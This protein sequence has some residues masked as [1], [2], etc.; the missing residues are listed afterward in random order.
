MVVVRGGT[1]VRQLLLTAATSKSRNSPGPRSSKPHTCTAALRVRAYLTWLPM[2]QHAA[3]I[4]STR[5]PPP[6]PSWA[7]AAR[8]GPLCPAW[9]L[10][11][12]QLP[13]PRH[14]RPPASPTAAISRSQILGTWRKGADTARRSTS[15]PKQ[16]WICVCVCASN[17]VSLRCSMS[18]KVPTK[19][20]TVS[21]MICNIQQCSIVSRDQEIEES[22]RSPIYLQFAASGSTLSTPLTTSNLLPKPTSSALQHASILPMHSA[23][24]LASVSHLVWTAGIPRLAMANLA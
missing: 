14:R 18:L 16:N 9:P 19:C 3:R 13:D 17:T 20:F 7:P 4:L 6:P 5:S 12:L 21:N 22:V 2:T 1:S 15:D 24:V 11:R 8:T 10:L 23:R